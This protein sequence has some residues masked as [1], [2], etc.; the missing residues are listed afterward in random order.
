MDE[1]ENGANY[2]MDPGPPCKVDL[3]PCSQFK[4]FMFTILELIFIIFKLYIYNFV[5]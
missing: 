4:N 3:G 2:A 1:L 5:T